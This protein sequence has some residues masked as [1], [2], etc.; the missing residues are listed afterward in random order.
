MRK[1]SL[2]SSA[3]LSS[4]NNNNTSSEPPLRRARRDVLETELETLKAEL[5]H[6]RSLRALDAKRFQKTQ[7]RLERQVEFAVTEAQ[8]AKTMMDESVSYTHLT[9]PTIA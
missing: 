5:E 8:E 4:S 7:D 9:L 1:R 3:L 2:E 6:A